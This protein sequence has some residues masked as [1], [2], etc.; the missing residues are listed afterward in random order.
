MQTNNNERQF[1]YPLMRI[2]DER[3][4]SVGRE[5]LPA[6]SFESYHFVL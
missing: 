5:G 4:F 1:Y 6:Q 3:N 2:R